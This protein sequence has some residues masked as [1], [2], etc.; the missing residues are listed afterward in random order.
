MGEQPRQQPRRPK[1]FFEGVML[2]WRQS[3]IRGGLTDQEHVTLAAQYLGLAIANMGISV[4]S[5]IDVMAAAA[6]ITNTACLARTA[7]KQGKAWPIQTATY[8]PGGVRQ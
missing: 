2:D 1:G 3:V 5:Q 6:R 8:G 4:E 7:V